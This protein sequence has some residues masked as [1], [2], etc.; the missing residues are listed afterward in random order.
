AATAKVTLKWDDAR[1]T[2]N[3]VDPANLV[4][5]HFTAGAWRT[6]G[7]SSGDGM[8]NSTGS[9]GPSNAIST[10]S[11]FTFGS[12]TVT[13]PIILG[14]FTVTDKDCH[15]LLNWHTMIEDNAA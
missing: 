8:G 13:L 9:V 10:F 1:N 2:L 11:P 14:A 4:V 3:H 5:A 15:A 6:E 12:T 7:G